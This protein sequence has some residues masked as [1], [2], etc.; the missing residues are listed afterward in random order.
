MHRGLSLTEGE[1]ELTSGLHR[2][3]ASPRVLTKTLGQGPGQRPGGCASQGG[4][5]WLPPPGEGACVQA[6]VA[7]A[8]FLELE[9]PNGPMASAVDTEMAGGENT[10]GAHFPKGTLRRSSSPHRDAREAIEGRAGV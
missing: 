10:S 2:Q 1:E 3:A 6:T 8:L 7:S 9:G 5:L 4:K